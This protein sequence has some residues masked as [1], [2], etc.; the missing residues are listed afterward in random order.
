LGQISAAG[1]FDGP[2]VQ[3]LPN[4]KKN[5]IVSRVFVTIAKFFFIFAF[6]CGGAVP[7]VHFYSK[8]P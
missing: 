4:T 2:G 5:T 1:I 6:K 8:N 7:K 3:R